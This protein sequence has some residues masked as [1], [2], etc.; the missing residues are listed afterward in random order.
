M[1]IESF[2]AF[3]FTSFLASILKWVINLAISIFVMLLKPI[4]E[5]VIEILRA[6]FNSILY[7][8]VFLPLLKILDTMR[9]AVNIFA[10]IRDISYNGEKGSLLN[11][12]LFRS[13]MSRVFWAVTLIGIVIAFA[14]G[15]MSLS[16]LAMSEK[17]TAGKVWG[18]LGKTM[19]TFLMVPFVVMAGLNLASVVF[20]KTA[21]SITL[22]SDSTAGVPEVLFATVTVGAEN[23]KKGNTNSSNIFSG[24]VQDYINGSKDY[25]NPKVVYGKSS[26]WGNSS[27]GDFNISKMHVILG[28]VE[29][30]YF[31][32]IYAAAILMFIIR[33]FEI[34]LLYIVSPLFV[35][36]IPTDEGKKFSEWREYFIAKILSGMSLIVGMKLFELIIVPLAVGDSVQFT[37]ST[38][39]GTGPYPEMTMRVL[40]LAASAF[41]FYKSFSL[42]TQLISPGAAQNE[43]GMLGKLFGIATVGVGLGG[44]I[45]VLG[46]KDQKKK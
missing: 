42:L 32:F 8:D 28:I 22:S 31:I 1:H 24:A 41:A 11:I 25:T 19:L 38:W 46:Q 21:E 35:S 18:R 6:I 9:E 23:V 26:G 3:S 14:A 36:T 12:I 10:G 45:L 43:Q 30:V 33:V 4:I 37:D 34:C 13:E 7:D 20:I 27:G 44:A 17:D 39:I 2:F 16:S 15:V 40:L 29:S 5:A